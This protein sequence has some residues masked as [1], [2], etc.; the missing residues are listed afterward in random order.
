[1]NDYEKAYIYIYI[2]N[3]ISENL[4]G[5]F[6]RTTAAF[7]SGTLLCYGTFEFVIMDNVMI[8]MKKK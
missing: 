1:V 5:A 8:I 4:S 6:G 7:F 2:I 3:K